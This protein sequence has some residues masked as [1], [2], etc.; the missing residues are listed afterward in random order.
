MDEISVE[1]TFISHLLCRVPDKPER[2]ARIY[3]AIGFVS[4]VEFSR[5]QRLQQ[6]TQVVEQAEAQENYG[7]IKTVNEIVPSSRWRRCED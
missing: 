4:D 3:V 2:R 5:L 1:S 7:P 6:L